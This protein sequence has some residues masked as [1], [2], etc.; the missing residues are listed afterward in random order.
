M[1]SQELVV[2]AKVNPSVLIGAENRIHKA[3][4]LAIWL[5]SGQQLQELNKNRWGICFLLA[6]IAPKSSKVIWKVVVER[7]KWLLSKFCVLW[8]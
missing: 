8:V 5:D 3:P 2:Y 1:F 7:V 6:N 4:M